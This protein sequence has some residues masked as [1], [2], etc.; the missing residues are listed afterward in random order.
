MIDRQA[1]AL[2]VCPVAT[3]MVPGVVV[4]TNCVLDLWLFDDPAT[5]ALRHAIETGA[6]RWLAVP[7]MR[8]ELARVLAYPLLAQQLARRDRTADGVLG[9]FDRWA[10]WVVAPAPAAVAC[11]DSDDQVFVDLAVAWRAVLVSRDR[12]VLA[13][14][15]RLRAWGVSVVA[16]GVM[17]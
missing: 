10:H 11:S 8:D 5:R 15:Y 12:E 16:R 9:A 3:G 7:A 13:L 1:S 2:G 6:M 14:A 4:D 17:P